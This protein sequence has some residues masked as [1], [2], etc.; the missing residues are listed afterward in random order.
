MIEL[1]EKGEIHPDQIFNCDETGLYWEK[2]ASRTFLTQNEKSASGFNRVPIFFVNPKS[3]TFPEEFQT[4]SLTFCKKNAHKGVNKI[5]THIYIY[6]IYY[7]YKY[8][9]GAVHKLR[10]TLTTWT[11]FC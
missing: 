2:M 1:L 7:Y 8:L 11:L 5:Y 6:N 9:L 3:L 4:F 10:N